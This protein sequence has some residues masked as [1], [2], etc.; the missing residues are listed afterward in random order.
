MHIILLIYR[1]NRTRRKA[2]LIT[3]MRDTLLEVQV[4][5]RLMCDLH[6]ISVGKYTALAEHTADMSRQMSAW[7]KSEYKKG[8]CGDG[9]ADD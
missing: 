6:Y 3:A 5:M 4:Y 1:A 2:P 7:E 8:S 9:G